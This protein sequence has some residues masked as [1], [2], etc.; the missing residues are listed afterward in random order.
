[1]LERKNELN[2]KLEELVA[3]LEEI[4][5]AYIETRTEYE[6]QVA[7]N[8]DTE[9]RTSVEKQVIE[10]CQQGDDFNTL[11][12]AVLRYRKIVE[13]IKLKLNI[14]SEQIKLL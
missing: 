9:S 8:M 3:Q 6:S 7:I 4:E 1:M 10:M 5:A 11:H 2:A 12:L 14:I 13:T